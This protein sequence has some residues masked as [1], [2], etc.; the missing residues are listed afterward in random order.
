MQLLWV[1]RLPSKYVFPFTLPFLCLS[2][3]FF[4]L[5]RLVSRRYGQG[6]GI[7]VSNLESGS[8]TSSYPNKQL[9]CENEFFVFSSLF[10]QQ[11][12]GGL[13]FSNLVLGLLIFFMKILL[14]I[15]CIL[16]FVYVALS[17]FIFMQKLLVFQNHGERHNFFF[18][19][20]LLVPRLEMCLQSSS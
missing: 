6:K 13:V 8:A 2:M 1:P 11:P 20:I 19:K 18:F 10:S 3:V 15:R 5:L 16:W 14:V 12:N 9:Y 4:L 7:E 17:L